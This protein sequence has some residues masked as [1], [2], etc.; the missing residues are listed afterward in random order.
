MAMST[1]SFF[2]GI[3]ESSLRDVMQPDGS[4]YGSYNT[5]KERLFMYC[6][7]IQIIKEIVM[8]FGII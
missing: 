8:P 2:G 1:G 5:T 7:T 6:H 3:F 4:G